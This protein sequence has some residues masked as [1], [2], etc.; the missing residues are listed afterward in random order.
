M[1]RQARNM[2]HTHPAFR[3]DCSNSSSSVQL[4]F[5]QHGPLLERGIVRC[6]DSKDG[7]C[8]ENV[9]RSLILPLVCG[10]GWHLSSI[11]AFHHLKATSR[12]DRPHTA[13]TCSTRSATGNFLPRRCRPP[14]RV[15]ASTPWRARRGTGFQAVS[16][17]SKASDKPASTARLIL[18]WNSVE[19][20]SRRS[21]STSTF[22][23]VSPR[24]AP[25]ASVGLHA[26]ESHKKPSFSSCCP[27]ALVATGPP[28]ASMAFEYEK[29]RMR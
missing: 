6:A 16:E 12:S 17:V 4:K 7:Y 14:Q 18:C 28:P 11:L 21:T 23:K 29:Q 2:S 5:K 27:C 26:P 9:L 13:W 3:R 8:F 10:W 20:P 24:H 15:S 1:E 19:Q 25:L 22:R